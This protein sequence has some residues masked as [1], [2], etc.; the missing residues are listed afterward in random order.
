V[1]ASGSDAALGGSTANLSEVGTVSG[2]TLA[3]DP[4]ISALASCLGNVV[5]A[6]IATAS[7]H[8][9]LG[10]KNPVAV[11][12]GVLQPSS[13]TA[14]AQ[15]VTCVAWPSAG[16]AG[17]YEKDVRQALAGR[18]IQTLQPFSSLLV[19][20][21]VS[22]LGDSQHIVRWQARTPG[23]ASLVLQMTEDYGLPAL[24]NCARLTHA[25]AAQVIGCH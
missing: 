10:G 6:D 15:A 2:Q 24:P 1:R 18:S 14:T 7:D 8:I 5:A 3:S 20:P 16:A 17:A 19:H 11:A 22:S 23:Q 9:S 12:V 25:A 4:L 21:S 13:A